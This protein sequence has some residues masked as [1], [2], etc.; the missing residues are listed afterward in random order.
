MPCLNEIAFLTLGQFNFHMFHEISQSTFPKH[1]T[2]LHVNNGTVF[3]FVLQHA[4]NN[5]VNTARDFHGR[6]AKTDNRFNQRRLQRNPP[7][8]IPMQ[9]RI[10][11]MKLPDN[12]FKVAGFTP[13]LSR[14]YNAPCIWTDF[15]MTAAIR[16]FKI[17]N[18]YLYVRQDT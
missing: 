5:P 17:S 6:T 2:H 14:F 4:R 18:L 13:E 9:L 16:S 3:L 12:L 7:I 1:R 10:F 11:F 8:G 15:V